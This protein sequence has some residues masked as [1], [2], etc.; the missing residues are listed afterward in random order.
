MS[1]PPERHVLRGAGQQLPTAAEWN[2]FVHELAEQASFKLNDT[3]RLD[4]LVRDLEEL[5]RQGR[6]P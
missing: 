4:Q 2:T 3:E 6:M 1:E 5:K